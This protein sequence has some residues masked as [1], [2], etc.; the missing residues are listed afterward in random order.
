MVG[1]LLRFWC[2]IGQAWQILQGDGQGIG[3]LLSMPHIQ[4]G[5]NKSL[6]QRDEAQHHTI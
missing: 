2:S 5:F 1:D 4:T 3:D 6:T